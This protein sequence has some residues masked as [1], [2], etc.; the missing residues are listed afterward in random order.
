MDEVITQAECYIK[1][2]ESNME[3]RSWEAKEKVRTKEEGAGHMKEYFKPRP[4]DRP[5]ARPSRRPFEKE[6]E[7][8]PLNARREDILRDV[9]HLKFLLILVCPKG[10]HTMME[11]TEV[12]GVRTI[13]F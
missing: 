11:K 10:M 6:Q 4:I 1:W 7:Y 8:T 9:Y 13:D 5:V 3:K 12:C 2:E